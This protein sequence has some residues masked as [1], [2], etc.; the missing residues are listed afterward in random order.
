MSLLDELSQIVQDAKA[1]RASDDRNTYYGWTK[2]QWAIA[3]TWYEHGALVSLN[4]AREIQRAYL[5][6]FGKDP[7]QVASTMFRRAAEAQAMWPLKL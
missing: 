1:H 5:D 6:R 4:T 2:E 7:V 3:L